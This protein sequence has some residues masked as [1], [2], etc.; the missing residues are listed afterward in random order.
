MA[1]T[2]SGRGDSSMGSP[3]KAQYGDRVKGDVKW[4]NVK[5][6]YGFIHRQ[7]TDTDIFVHQSA[8]KQKNPSQM[9]RSLKEGEEVEFYVVEG[10][11]GDEASEVTG[12]AGA[13]V[14]GSVYA[15]Y[16]GR[17]RPYGGR[18]MGPGSFTNSNE[19]DGPRMRGRGGGGGR[20]YGYYDMDPRGPPMRRSWG[21]GRGYRGARF[22]G[23]PPRGAYRGRR[24]NDYEN[25]MN[26][27]YDDSHE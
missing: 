7:D 11:K 8:I 26:N 2:E 20:M 17:G 16:R 27:G 19:F 14:Q 6:G 1:D 4:F 21:R 23:G 13:P 18:G 10:E 12:P 22:D 25:G 5:S 15:D 3:S 24:G 9:R